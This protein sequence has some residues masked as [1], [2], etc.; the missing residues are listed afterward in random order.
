MLRLERALS[1]FVV[2]GVDTTIP[3]FMKLLTNDDFRSGNY[4]IKWLEQFLELE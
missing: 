3:L 2:E 4:H 1:E